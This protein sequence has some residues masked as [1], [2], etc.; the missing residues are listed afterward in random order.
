MGLNPCNV[1]SLPRISNFFQRQHSR[2]TIQTTCS[3]LA[4]KSALNMLNR[5]KDN[6]WYVSRMTKKHMELRMGIPITSVSQ[7]RQMLNEDFRQEL[8]TLGF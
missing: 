1:S 3:T 2:Q 4:S 8:F 5:R 6:E 7:F